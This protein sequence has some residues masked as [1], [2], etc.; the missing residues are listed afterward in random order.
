[1]D[2][3]YTEREQREIE[4]GAAAYDEMCREE[5]K[6]EMP[7]VFNPLIELYRAFEKINLEAIR[8]YQEDIGTLAKVR[9]LFPDSQEI[10][11]RVRDLINLEA[12]AIEEL[13]KEIEN[14]REAHAEFKIL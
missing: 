2:G 5:L 9:E 10:R 11:D 13:K 1:M 12:F 4:A 14:D 7:E 8:F 3:C 6:A